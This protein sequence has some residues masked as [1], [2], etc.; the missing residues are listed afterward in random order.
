MKK[1]SAEMTMGMIVA[2]AIAVIIL[3]LSIWQISTGFDA[4]KK[5]TNPFVGDSNV[6]DVARGCEVSCASGSVYDYCTRKVTVNFGEGYCEPED[7]GTSCNS[8]VKDTCE[9]LDD[10]NYINVPC[11]IC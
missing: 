11:N 7:E 6:D 9:N 10:A 5:V 2:I 4:F 8:T 3:I 1:K